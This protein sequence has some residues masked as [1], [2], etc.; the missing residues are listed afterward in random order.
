MSQR[1][2]AKVLGVNQA[3]ISRDVM[4]DA[5]KDDA[6]RIAGSAATRAHRAAVAG[7]AR[8]RAGLRALE[9]ALWLGTSHQHDAPAP[10]VGDPDVVV[11]VN[12]DTQVDDTG[13]GSYG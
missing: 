6:K 8:W 10:E 1:Q 3:T 11:A 4:H 12:G 9:M 7:R 2:A 5:S 13:F